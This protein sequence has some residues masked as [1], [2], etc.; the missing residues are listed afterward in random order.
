MRCQRSASQN[1]KRLPESQCATDVSKSYHKPTYTLAVDHDLWEGTMV[2]ATMRSGYRSGGINT[3][4]Q[5]IAALTALPVLGVPIERFF[6]N[7]EA[8][9]GFTVMDRTVVDLL[10]G[11]Y[12]IRLL[13]AFSKIADST[14]RLALVKFAEGL[15][16]ESAG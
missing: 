15:D 4:A 5:N 13:R 14:V 2:Y 10:E 1:R 3:Q 9:A 7:A 16:D 8:P 11:P 6:E 12:A